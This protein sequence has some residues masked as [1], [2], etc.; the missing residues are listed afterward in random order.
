[1]KHMTVEETMLQTLIHNNNQLEKAAIG[2]MTGKLS[3]VIAERIM[4]NLTR[5]EDNSVIHGLE[6]KNSVGVDYEVELARSEK[7]HKALNDAIREARER[8]AGLEPREH[9]EEPDYSGLLDAVR[10][11]VADEVRKADSRTR[12][13]DDDGEPQERPLKGRPIH[14][15][16]N[17]IL[18]EYK[19]D[20]DAFFERFKGLARGKKGRDLAILV[21]A[22]VKGKL[23]LRPTFGE[24]QAAIGGDIGSESGY[25]KYKIGGR[26]VERD[27][28]KVWEE[29]LSDKEIDPYIELLKDY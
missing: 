23:M 12:G 14:D 16:R 9:H 22:A 15:L 7:A 29:K 27:G 5:P 20:G 24:L 19:Y 4:L 8:A 3:T 13:R 2:V 6:Y 28:K 1:M 26:Y 25:N 21:A 17:K 11:T 10:E 18:C